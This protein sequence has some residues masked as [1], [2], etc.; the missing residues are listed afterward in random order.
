VLM[1]KQSVTS[2]VLKPLDSVLMRNTS[3][4]ASDFDWLLAST[5]PDAVSTTEEEYNCC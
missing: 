1:Y 5:T 3:D 4:A 2:E